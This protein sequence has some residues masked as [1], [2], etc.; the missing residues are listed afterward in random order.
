VSAATN[1]R[2]KMRRVQIEISDKEFAQLLATARRE[3]IH[4]KGV[5]DLRGAIITVWELPWADADAWRY[6]SKIGEIHFQ[7][8]SAT[9]PPTIRRL[10]TYGDHTADEMLWHLARLI[11]REPKSMAGLLDG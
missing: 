9:T 7:H 4:L 11:G 2:P 8:P 5:Y 3:D 10:V 6:L 1:A